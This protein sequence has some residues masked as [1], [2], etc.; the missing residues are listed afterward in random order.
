MA[1]YGAKYIMWAPFAS[2]N[3]E[4]ENSMP[5]YDA[6]KKIQLAKL[7]KVTDVPNFVEGKL[8][9]DNELVEYV[10]VCSDANVEAEITHLL[11]TA[12]KTIFGLTDVTDGTIGY[13]SEDN[14]PYGVLAFIT[15][16]INGGKAS[17]SG[18]AYPKCKATP[19]GAEYNTR[20]DSITFTT[21]KLS[22]VAQTCNN[23]KWKIEPEEEFTTETQAKAWVDSVISGTLVSTV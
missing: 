1:K 4:P 5:V 7:V 10:K 3:P 12:A 8:Y 6:T 23:G 14:A 20:N 9:G 2:A 13:G 15:C 19:S 17:F 11:N 16:N 21:G 22:L 18:V